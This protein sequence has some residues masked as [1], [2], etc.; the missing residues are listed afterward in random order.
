MASD[1]FATIDDQ[2]TLVKFEVPERVVQTV[3]VEIKVTTPQLIKPVTE[4]AEVINETTKSFAETTEEPSTTD[5]TDFDTTESATS[6][7]DQE[8]ATTTASGAYSTDSHIDTTASDCD[9]QI[10]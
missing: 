8:A 6:R 4:P 1:D 5:P 10:D 7:V 9:V 2:E 3:Q